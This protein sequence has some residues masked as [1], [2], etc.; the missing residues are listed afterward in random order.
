MQIRNKE[1]ELLFDGELHLNTESLDLPE[2]VLE[3][4]NLQGAH[5]DGAN[6]Q[7]ANL[8]R[9][10]LYWA[11]FF[12]ADLSGADLEGAQLQGSDLKRATLTDANLHN[13]NLGRDNLG[14][15]TSLQGAILNC[16]GLKF[17]K[18]EGAEYDANT[19][20]PQDFDPKKFG[21]IERP[22]KD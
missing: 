20:F 11:H 3:G 1:G 16:V 15:S 6:L 8:R 18:L 7:G 10:D 19:V 17:A 13:A 12:L 5:F 22:V 9:A 2:A 21:M 4:Q 14:G